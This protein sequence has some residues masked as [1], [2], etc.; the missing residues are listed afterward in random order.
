LV[1]KTQET[2]QIDGMLDT[3]WRAAKAARFLLDE[4]PHEPNNDFNGVTKTTIQMKALYDDSLQKKNDI[5]FYS[6]LVGSMAIRL[7]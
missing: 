3:D 2:I 1:L 7:I 6:L 5:L 4:M